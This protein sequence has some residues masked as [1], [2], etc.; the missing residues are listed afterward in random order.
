MQEAIADS[1]SSFFINKSDKLVYD[2]KYVLNIPDGWDFVVHHSVLSNY[3]KYLDKYP[4]FHYIHFN[5]IIDGFPVFN[6]EKNFAGLISPAIIR[7]SVI[8][9]VKNLSKYPGIHIPEIIYV[10]LNKKRSENQES[11]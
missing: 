5:Y 7:T 9:D 10:K 4:N 2:Y 6:N 11:Q 3:I 8:K 1:K